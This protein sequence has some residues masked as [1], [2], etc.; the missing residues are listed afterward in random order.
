MKL[1]RIIR[2]F[3]WQ[4]KM[5]KTGKFLTNLKNKLFKRDNLDT[6]IN[7]S[8]LESK[9]LFLKK[10]IQNQPSKHFLE[11]GPKSGSH[12]LFIDR[13]FNPTHLTLLERPGGGREE[14]VKKWIG[15]IQCETSEV[16]S[17]LL[18]AHQLKDDRYDVIFCLGV[19]YHN[20]EYFKTFKFFWD[21]LNPSS[22]LVLGT[23]L[24]YDKRPTIFINY[25]RGQLYDL[26]RPSRSAMETIGAMTGFST[27]KSYD[28]P[29][30]NQRGLF[31]FQKIE[32]PPI[33]SGGCD[34]GG[35]TV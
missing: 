9:L 6:T 21:L 20:V 2:D 11:I 29:M 31:I 34:F 32:K 27:L 25:E 5:Y 18:T 17:D 8:Q 16:Y 33:P 13:F 3:I 4:H 19:V 1:A 7:V 24:S 15:N 35:S 22:Y 10:L 23:V 28:L 30:P 12:S 14:R 26:T